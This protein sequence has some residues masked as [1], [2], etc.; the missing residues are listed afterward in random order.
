MKRHTLTISVK[1]A[2]GNLYRNQ[3]VLIAV[4]N[5]EGKILIGAKPYMFPPTIARLLGGGVDESEDIK[6]AA[7]RELEEELGVK[8]SPEA[9]TELA[10]FAVDARD[11]DGHTFHNDTYVYHVNI[12]DQKFRPGDDVEHIV[13][14]TPDELYDLGTT[15][16]KLP[17]R[18]WYNGPEGTYSWADY[19]KMYGP[20]HQ[21][22]ADEV[23]KLSSRLTRQ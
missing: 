2:F 21:I 5:N 10:L 15:Y 3:C 16:L 1:K 14:L 23:K 11:E 12:R 17:E 8:T 4:E 9:L 18:L 7:V 13:I 20:I 22:V 6:L 19:A